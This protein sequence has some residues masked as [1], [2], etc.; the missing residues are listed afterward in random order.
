MSLQHMLVLAIFLTQAV[1]TRATR[2]FGIWTLDHV[3]I[4]NNSY[5]QLNC[6]DC[7]SIQ[8]NASIYGVV[9][10]RDHKALMT[11]NNGN[12]CVEAS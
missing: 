1:K 12:S 11:Q 6:P 4:H 2:R 10:I 5:R 8:W 3:S 7:S 9:K